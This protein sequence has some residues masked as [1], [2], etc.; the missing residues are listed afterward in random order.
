MNQLASMF[1]FTKNVISSISSSLGLTVDT[2]YIVNW[3]GALN[4]ILLMLILSGLLLFISIPIQMAVANWKRAESV[5]DKIKFKQ[6]VRQ[7]CW[8]R[9]WGG[10]I[11]VSLPAVI[12][13][14]LQIAG[15]FLP[16]NIAT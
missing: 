6:F 3:A 11:L 7:D 16:L 10:I 5:Q 15:S 8:H 14:V 1:G 4:L 9:F 13:I 2:S 12:I